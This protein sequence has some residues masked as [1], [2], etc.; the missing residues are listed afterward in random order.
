MIFL[1]T[2]LDI[3]KIY[4]EKKHIF[5]YIGDKLINRQN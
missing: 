4:A 2:F 1:S 5:R 3:F